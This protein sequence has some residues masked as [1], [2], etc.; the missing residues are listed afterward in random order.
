[1]IFWT[2]YII[3]FIQF[4]RSLLSYI[5]KLY[6]ISQLW[7]VIE[8]Y[9]EKILAIPYFFSIKH[10]KLNNIHCAIFEH[11]SSN[12]AH[13]CRLL[14]SFQQIITSIFSM[15]IFPLCS[16]LLNWAIWHILFLFDLLAEVIC[17]KV[18]FNWIAYDVVFTKWN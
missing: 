16:H 1:M 6:F 11:E 17:I 8:P 9:K 12:S 3:F 5:Y 15:L 14:I 10:R 2:L 18:F 7:N 13:T 4:R